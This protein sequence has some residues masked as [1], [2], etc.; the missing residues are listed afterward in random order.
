MPGMR[1]SAVTSQVCTSR[2]NSSTLTPGQ[3]RQRDLRADAGDLLHVAEQPALGFAQEAVQRDA[4]FLLRVMG[5]QRTPRG[6]RPAGRRRCSS[7]LPARSRRHARRPPATAA[8]V[9]EDAFESPD[10]RA[11]PALAAPGRACVD[12][13]PVGAGA[14]VRMGDRHRQRVGGVGLQLCSGRFSISRTMCCTCVLSAAPLP[15]QRQ[16]DLPWRRTRSPA[17]R[18]A[19]RRAMAAPRAWPELERRHRVA[20][21]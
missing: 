21:P 1:V 3:H 19:T 4:V 5:E 2:A 14:H 17:G 15:D 18:R 13:Q 16:L 20:C 9:D 8:L 6:R 11:S 10:H 12:A 7:A